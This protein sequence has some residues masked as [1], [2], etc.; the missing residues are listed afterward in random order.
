MKRIIYCREVIC[1]DLL[2]SN[3]SIG[4]KDIMKSIKA[5]CLLTLL[6]AFK[7]SLL[8]QSTSEMQGE[9]HPELEGI[10]E[11]KIPGTNPVRTQQ[12]YGYYK[13]GAFILIDVE[14]GERNSFDLINEKELSF[15]KTF[16]DKGR[17]DIT[18]IKDN[19]E[20]KKQFRLQSNLAKMDEIVTQV[21]S[22][23][24][25]KM[26]PGTAS[27]RVCYL[28]RHYNKA[29]YRIPMRDG[30]K[31]YTQVFTPLGSATQNPF[32]LFRTPYGIAPYGVE[33][34]GM[35]F[36][37]LWFAM[38]D[39][40]LV[41]QEVR[42]T[43]CSEGDFSYL[44]PYIVKK[45]SLDNVDESSDAFDT[46]EWLLENIPDNNG[47]VGVWGSSYPG[48]TSVM[49]A[50]SGHPAIAAVSSQA[51]M[52]DLFLG[53]DGHH[54]GALYLAHYFNY[55]FRMDQLRGENEVKSGLKRFRYPSPDAYTYL[56]G[57]GTLNNITKS[58]MG[59]DNLLWNQIMDH[60]TYDDFW[61]SHSVN[62]Y[63]PEIKPAM[64]TVG[65]WYDGED[66]LGTLN[67]YKIKERNR[68]G[69]ENSIVMGPWRHSGWNLLSNQNE[70]IGAFKFDST[71][72]FFQQQIELPFFNYYLKN[73]G[74][75]HKNEAIVYETGTD[76]WR[77]FSEWPPNEAVIKKLFLAESGKLSFEPTTSSAGNDF[78]EY[79]SDPG[80][81]VPYTSSISS[82]YN[83][84]YFVED[85]RFASSRPDVLVY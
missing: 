1:K 64:L 76:K 56:L 39:Y 18:F 57:L 61:K 37:S 50:L 51:P 49:A 15:S 71:G 73:K 2:S 5:V 80:K 38:E 8:A 82:T 32:M 85:Q 62:K 81:P 7:I 46:I 59:E 45:E 40:I 9:Q 17:F 16:Q 58:V 67:L 79:I 4:R 28:E 52:M 74:D 11:L 22:L 63:V 55:L 84:D 27:D 48:F 75:Y 54:N 72:R 60:E 70:S 25:S 36:P 78:D 41:Y 19:G 21:G 13:N 24:D 43:F 31:L 26:D 66:L 53:D 12:W 33:F 44:N 34:S 68:K 65:G 3:H 30:V 42:G 77:T 14:D 23:D 69:Q 83:K 29:E 47:K 6:L 20:G 35:V 10:Y